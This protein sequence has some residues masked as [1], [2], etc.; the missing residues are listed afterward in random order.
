[1]VRDAVRFWLL[2]VLLLAAAPLADAQ[3]YPTRPI[4]LIVPFTPGSGIDI[5]ARTLGQ[6]LT[7]RWGQPVVVDNKPGAS[8]GPGA[9]LVAKAP[10]HR[11]PVTVAAA[12]Q[13]VPPP[14]SPTP[15]SRPPPPLSPP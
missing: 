9:E 12:A 7:E 4:A 5:I 14:P 15:P 11:H 13:A 8:G 2:P 3:T 6:K 10:P 1:M